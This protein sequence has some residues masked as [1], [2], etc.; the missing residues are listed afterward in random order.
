MFQISAQVKY[1][2]IYKKAAIFCRQKKYM[3]FII[4]INTHFLTYTYL[5]LCI[6]VPMSSSFKVIAR[7][8]ISGNGCPISIIFHILCLHL[9]PI[10]IL[11]HENMEIGTISD[12]FMT[13]SH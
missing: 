2:H 9:Y 3:T 12:V 10:L 4:I 7:R 11:D 6:H 5:V 13:I 1:T 8:S